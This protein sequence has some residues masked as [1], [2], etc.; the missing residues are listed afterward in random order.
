MEDPRRNQSIRLPFETDLMMEGPSPLDDSSRTLV[1]KTPNLKPIHDEFLDFVRS[2]DS[3]SQLSLSVNDSASDKTFEEVYEIG[4]VLGEGGFAFVYQCRH[5][6][7]H[8]TYA[9]KEVLKKDHTNGDEIKD[10]IAALRRV[11]ECPHFVRLLDVFSEPKTTFLVMEE[12]KGGDLLDKLA[13]I[14]VYEEWEARKVAR[15][16][17]EAVQ[18]CHKRKI[19]HRDIKPENILLPRADDITI[20]KLADFGCAKQWNKPNEMHTLCG[21]PQYVAPEVV[22]DTR[23]EGEGYNCQCDLWSCGVGKLCSWGFCCTPCVGLSHIHAQFDAVMF[24]L[25]GGMLC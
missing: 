21:S 15:T 7:N 18:Y 25:L 3:I 22:G 8:H 5:R 20:I 4:E 1:D 9:V 14:E 23:A 6:S 10:E 13:E 24:I 11:K 16:L 2:Q 12:M 17:L 19:A